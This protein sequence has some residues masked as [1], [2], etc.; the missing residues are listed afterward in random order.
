MNADRVI[1]EV[2]VTQGG[3]QFNSEIE[4]AENESTRIPC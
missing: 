1:M 3:R 4:F 2:E